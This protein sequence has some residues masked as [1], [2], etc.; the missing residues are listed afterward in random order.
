MARILCITIVICEPNTMKLIMENHSPYW[1]SC[2]S[3]K[4][5]S[6]EE[7]PDLRVGVMRDET[8]I[9]HA[10]L[11]WNHVPQVDGDVLGVIGGFHAENA[12]AARLL[13]DESERIF[14]KHQC[15]RIV[16]PMNGNTWRKHRFVS[17]SDG[18]PPYLLEP[19]SPSEH[20]AWWLNC[21]Y[22][23]LEE[24]SSSRMTI[25]PENT[26]SSLVVERLHRNGVTVRGVE[27]DRLEEE[28][29]AIHAICLQCFR[30]NFLYT[31]MDCGEFVSRYQLLTK[32]IST[33]YV[34][35]AFCRGE[36]C[37]FIFSMPDPL[38]MQR[39]DESSL[40][41]KTLAV[42]PNREFAGLGTLLVEQVHIAAMN[43]GIHHSIHALQRDD[44]TSRRITNRFHGRIFRKYQILSK[45]I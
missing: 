40:I 18:S 45:I 20:R 22:S 9:A 41:V 26:I 5:V 39:G 19:V 37:G 7:K 8:M 23:V 44:N 16:G 32:W 1:D 35:L 30:N 3:E 17:W 36:L 24:Y 4:L 15:S 13:L 38:A 28:L 33:D 21:G 25:H 11:W 12:E 42:L 2:Y 10:A 34:R 6:R 27:L 14:C 31:P 29:V 43:H